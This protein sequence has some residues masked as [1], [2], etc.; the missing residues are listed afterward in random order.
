MEEI[1]CEERIVM[2]PTKKGQGHTRIRMDRQKQVDLDSSNVVHV[3]GGDHRG[4]VINKQTE[5]VSLTDDPPH[6]SLEF[7]VFLTNAVNNDQTKER[8]KLLF[9][10]KEHISEKE[11]M[12]NAQD[13]FKELI[14][15]FEFPRDYVGFIK[16][17]M[18]LMQNRYVDIKR[19]EVDM[20]QLDCSKIELPIHAD[21]MNDLSAP[22]KV[23]LT[24][25]KV[26]EMIE[27]A[28]P[29][30]LSVE[31][32]S[33]TFQCS[34]EELIDILNALISTGL[35]KNMG[36]GFYSRVTQNDT[37]VKLVRQMPTVVNAK[38]P[39]IA[40]ITAQYCEKLA[41]D[42]MIEN[43]DTYVRYKTEGDS[44]VYTLGNIGMHRVVST[45]LPAV[46]HS[47]SAMISAGNTMTR[48][49]GIF[50][51]VEY[52]FLVGVGGGV[53][54]YTDYSKH[55]RLGDI[56]V[57]V[58]AKDLLK[59]YIYLYCEKTWNSVENA[60]NNLLTSTKNFNIKTWNPPHMH[61]QTVAQNLWE[62]Y[63]GGNDGFCPWKVYSEEGLKD[64]KNQEADFARPAEES[65]KLFM[66]IGG[67]DVIEVGHPSP[68]ENSF[69]PRQAGLPVV[70]FGA[71]GSGRHLMRD[72][73]LRLEFANQNGLLAY[74]KEFDSVIESIH[75][76][77][78]DNYVFIRGIAD[79]KDGTEQK[80]WQPYA[81]LIAASFMK[82]VICSL[83]P[84]DKE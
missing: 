11:K 77:R 71:I 84:Y 69:D 2:T 79:Y 35:I 80:D 18:K 29:N 30:S 41:V 37:E 14:S 26:L 65:D 68:P 20:K 81:S 12:H 50:Q 38:Q 55:V 13:F 1:T 32:M 31:D 33:N 47:R 5:T 82:A 46:G 9:W 57:S 51:R 15:P 21:M 36:K 48:L 63:I 53:P 34:E 74:D 64:L 27:S 59:K 83:E 8:R 45:K 42:A 61:L 49:L 40:I 3:A 72:D 7:K 54:H 24:K 70:H 58:P 66:C 25:V 62:Q 52:I 56:V 19:I 28:Y 76:N 78:K 23:Q 39:T 16:K 43:K 75:G 22:L 73:S 6:L 44:N 17:I 10:F 4:I 67:K 60:S